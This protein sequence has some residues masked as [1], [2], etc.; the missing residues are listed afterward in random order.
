MILAEFTFCL[1]VAIRVG[2]ESAFE[3][4]TASMSEVP[5]DA[6]TL[7]TGIVVSLSLLETVEPPVGLLLPLSY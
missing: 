2:R 6:E 7:S 3:F 5:I 1:K 4:L